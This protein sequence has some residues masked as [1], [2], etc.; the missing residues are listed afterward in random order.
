[1]RKTALAMLM[2]T[3]LLCCC[4]IA[5]TPVNNDASREAAT[6]G[7]HLTAPPTTP[8]AVSTAVAPVLA[9]L[10]ALLLF[11]AAQRS[12]EPAVVRGRRVRS[13]RSLLRERTAQ[14]RGPPALAI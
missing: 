10:I 9:T 13:M 3:A 11:V 7:I 12:A 4:L 6:A 2:L 8:R 5:G 14:R 1:M